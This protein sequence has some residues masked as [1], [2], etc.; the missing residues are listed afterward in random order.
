MAQINIL[1]THNTRSF[2]V[3]LIIVIAFENVI[4][5]LDPCIIL[6]DT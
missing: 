2:L 1:I 6:V 3:L 4:K 5:T